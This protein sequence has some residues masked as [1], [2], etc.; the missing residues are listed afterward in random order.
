[1]HKDGSLKEL[2]KDIWLLLKFKYVIRIGWYRGIVLTHQF[3]LNSRRY[4]N[5]WII[6]PNHTNSEEY[7]Y[8]YLIIIRQINYPRID[9]LIP[10][11]WTPWGIN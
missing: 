10:T 6:P 5:L 3:C 4:N 7:S 1:M 9:Y 11:Q 2:L 8:N